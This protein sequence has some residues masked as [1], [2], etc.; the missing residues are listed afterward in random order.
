[1]TATL[2]TPQKLRP[3]RCQNSQCSEDPQGRLIFDFWSTDGVCP[4]CNGT[5]KGGGLVIA[6]AIIHFHPPSGKG[7]GSRIRPCDGQN[8]SHKNS[9]ATPV[10][11]EVTCPACRETD[12]WRK[13]N[14]AWDDDEQ[15]ENW[16]LIRAAAE[17][18][19]LSSAASDCTIT[20][21]PATGKVSKE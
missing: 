20:F 21:N 8:I 3:Y 4:K 11:A 17:R 6:L 5:N 19:G 12:V 16:H 7:M 13:L 9:S 2:Q 1:M 15:M 14:E 18:A 10:P